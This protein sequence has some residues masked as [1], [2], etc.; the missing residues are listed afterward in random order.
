MHNLNTFIITGRSALS[1]K[2]YIQ[3][4]K[5]KIIFDTSNSNFNFFWNEK[6]STKC[7]YRNRSIIYSKKLS[8]SKFKD[9]S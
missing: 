7:I 4:K 6:L 3:N 9:F 5:R 8:A 2:K 1:K